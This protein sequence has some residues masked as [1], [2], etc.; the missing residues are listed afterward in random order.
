MSATIIDIADDVV[1]KINAATLSISV[2]A[3][4]A[5]VPKF[6]LHSDATVQIKVVPRS[7]SRVMQDQANDECQTIIDVAVYK[8]LQNDLADE[9]TEV[10]GLLVLCDE[11]RKTLN[12]VALAAPLDAT[13]IAVTQEPIYGVDE[14]DEHRIFL[15]VLSFTYY[16]TVAIA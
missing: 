11:I 4:R 5:Y 9:A 15:S 8:K 10:D 14:M 13:C 2:T 3:V 7:D 6:D 1:T 16:A 12:R